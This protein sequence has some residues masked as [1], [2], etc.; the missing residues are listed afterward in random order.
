MIIVDSL[1]VNVENRITMISQTEGGNQA[2]PERR[3]ITIV[4]K[5]RSHN[6]KADPPR[7]PGDTSRG[8][9]RIS[10]AESMHKTNRTAR[11]K[12]YLYHGDMNA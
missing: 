6:V 10:R 11:I 3:Y 12:C 8:E 5:G 4:S 9:G 2:E 7:I 1:F